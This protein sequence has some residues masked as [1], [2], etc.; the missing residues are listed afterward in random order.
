MMQLSPGPG[1]SP[2]PVIATVTLLLAATPARGA[3]LVDVPHEIATLFFAS[4]VI[5]H[6]FI[7]HVSGL[8]R[9][10]GDRT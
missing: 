3:L 5:I 10:L 9:V 1:G 7:I 2:W 4:R 8:D 6:L